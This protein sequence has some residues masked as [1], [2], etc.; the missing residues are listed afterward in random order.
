MKKEKI[1]IAGALWNLIEVIARAVLGFIYSLLGKELSDE[2][3]DAFMQFVKFGM[4]GFMNT[5]LSYLIYT[6]SLLL[7]R[8]MGWFGRYDYFIAQVTAFVL[9]VLSS[10]IFNSIF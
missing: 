3:F 2:G 8:K 9:S 10:Y 1:G 5:I 4:V 7:Y 6:F